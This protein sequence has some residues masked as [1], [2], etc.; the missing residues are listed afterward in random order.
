MYLSL[1]SPTPMFSTRTNCLNAG[2]NGNAIC[3]L[4]CEDFCAAWTGI[5]NPDPTEAGAC[6]EACKAKGGGNEPVCRFELLQRAIYD[7]RYCDYVKFG[8]GSC[9]SCN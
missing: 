1:L 7:K 9:F 2:P 3:G 6:V 8:P 4:L 5:C